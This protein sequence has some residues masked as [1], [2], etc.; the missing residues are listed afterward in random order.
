MSIACV[1]CEL[2][3]SVLDG[4]LLIEGGVCGTWAF[5]LARNRKE[6]LELGITYSLELG[7]GWLC[8]LCVALTLRC[9]FGSLWNESATVLSDD[10][11]SRLGGC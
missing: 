4:F 8:V 5:G 1:F 6:E 7:L 11:R 2:L 3:A 10:L 9:C